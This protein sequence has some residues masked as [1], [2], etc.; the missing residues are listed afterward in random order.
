LPFYELNFRDYARIFHKR[1]FII[2]FTFLVVTIGS[3]IFFPKP[4]LIYEASTTVKIEERKT[5]A[6]LL[7]EWIV[8]NPGDI[9]A[10]QTKIIKGF[11][12]MKK[13]ALRM[14]RINYNS[15]TSE[16]HEVVS[17]LQEKIA[18]E[19]IEKTNLIKITASS[20]SAKEAMDLATIV[21]EVYVEEN[22]LEKTKQARST[23][24][25]IEEQLSLLESRLR[26][27][28]D[29]LKEFEDR[30]GV[31]ED[32]RKK[33]IEDV[34][35]VDPLQQKLMDLEF[36]LATLVLKYTDKHPRI[37]RIKEQIS[38][39]EQQREERRK[40]EGEKVLDVKKKDVAG[41]K[42][43]FARLAREV[44]VNKKLYMMFKEKLEEARINEA[45]KVGDISIVNPAVMPTAPVTKQ[46][47]A[48]VLI[49]ALIGLLLG[50]AFAFILESLD[51]SI[52][53]IED[54]E[55][56]IELPVLGVIPSAQKEINRKKLIYLKKILSTGKKEAE[57]S[58]IRMLVHQQP[59][60]PISEAFRNIRTNL[61]LSP[62]KKAILFTSAGPEEGKTTIMLNIGLAVA[63]TGARTLLVSTDL[64]RPVIAKT[65][66]MSRE[67]GLTELVAG[68][69]R[70]E[71][72]IK[73][74][75]DFA[76]ADTKYNDAIKKFPGLENVWI[77]PSGRIP[78]NPAEILAFKKLDNIIEE[79]KERFDF[80]LFDSPPVLPV[81]DASLL[82]SKVDGVVLCYEIGKI[83][84]EALVR[85]KV[86]LELVGAHISG[87]V[88]NHIK[89]Q[90][91]AISPYPY[92]YSYK[93]GES[94]QDIPGETA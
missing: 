25:F 42:L 83:S 1:K 11:P 38:N 29:R 63:Q 57:K 59:K 12:I 30:I 94:D 62:S 86:Q 9:M 45:Q 19:T 33:V 10:S 75:S 6:G 89:Q 60:S 24:Q 31:G 53:T 8:Y 46:D 78:V 54:V 77:L 44:E 7:T 84:R 4:P 49:G 34:G 17:D 37:L 85:A 15:P 3:I 13:V 32:E 36:K 64:R 88:L 67:P 92:Y 74:I 2:I 48:H 5:I 14:G 40:A 16:I 51:T 87:I 68:M 23:R 90:T 79:L 55:K 58:Y 76:T 61:K 91:K 41:Q 56:G 27:S 21:A 71:E 80:V 70:L 39:L 65:F 69:V 73:S 22:L 20:G 93:Y 43:K 35:L 50:I 18:T 72:A 47:K 26:N 52:G 82:A 81:T 66:G 28:E